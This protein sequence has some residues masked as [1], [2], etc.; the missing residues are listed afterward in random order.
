MGVMGAGKAYITSFDPKQTLHLFRLGPN[1]G[2]NMLKL[3]SLFR[4]IDKAIDV[5]EGS[6]VQVP[7]RFKRKV[8]N[9]LL[10]VIGSK[11]DTL[12]FPDNDANRQILRAAV[13]EKINELIPQAVRDVI[14]QDRMFA[15]AM[16]HVQDVNANTIAELLPKSKNKGKY[17]FMYAFIGP[18]TKKG[19]HS[20]KL[21]VAAFAKR[22]PGTF[23]RNSF[24]PV[25]HYIAEVLCTLDNIDGYAASS[26]PSET[27]EMFNEE[28]MICAHSIN[29]L[30][31]V[32]SVP[33]KRR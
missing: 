22:R 2:W 4:V 30:A 14:N 20:I 24:T 8:A 17:A 18:D 19:S 27:D 11:N 21:D 7:S 28:V 29:K 10:S 15:A 26:Y 3:Y 32:S 25:D 16:T 13:I 6:Y 5:A 9:A 12:V 33:I 1:S 31:P 23:T